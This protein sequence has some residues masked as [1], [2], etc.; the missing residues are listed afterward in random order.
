MN[1]QPERS[2]DD[3]SGD[4]LPLPEF[5]AADVRPDSDFARIAR[6]VRRRSAMRGAGEGFTEFAKE[7]PEMVGGFIEMLLP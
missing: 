6:R 3:L 7:V 1:S 5:P 4:T 2:S